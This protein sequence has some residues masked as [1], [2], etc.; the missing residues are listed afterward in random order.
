MLHFDAQIFIITAALLLACLGLYLYSTSRHLEGFESSKPRCPDMLIQ[1]GSKI[2]L[3][4]SKLAK[5]PG[6]NPIEFENLEDYTE[7]LD[8][9]RSQGIRCPVLFLQKSF[10][11]QGNSVFKVRPD[12]HNPQG[13][14]PPS[15]GSGVNPQ[16]PPI[17][18]PEYDPALT[19]SYLHKDS[20]LL[21][22][23]TRNNPPYNQNLYPSFDQ[24]AYYDGMTTPLDEMDKQFE[25][26]GTISA[27]P[28]DSNWG[29]ADYTQTLVDKGYYKDNEVAIRIS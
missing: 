20:T 11:A 9:Q 26:P 14:L 16:Q 29:G 4:N 27:N 18:P 6:V 5:I 7:F 24:S 13:G 3:Y 17:Q 2:Y 22:D 1:E 15:T 25:K 23:A 28:M 21:V 12:I 8:W 10:D 19:D